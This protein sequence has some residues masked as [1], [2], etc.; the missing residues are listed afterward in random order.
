MNFSYNWLKDYFQKLPLPEK[1]ADV[2]TMHSFEVESV[3]KVGSDYILDIDVL[4]NRAA[5]CFS[6][7]GLAREIAA[8]L[9]LKIKKQ[10]VAKIR[11]QKIKTKDFISVKVEDKKSCLRYTA[12]VV[13]EVKV[14]PSP[15][16]IQER[17]ISCGL[18][19]INNI[20]DI[21]NYVMLE[22]GQPLH[23]FDFEKIREKKLIVRYANP[24]EKITTLDDKKFVLGE[25]IL[26]IA[27]PERVLAIAGI[28]GGKAAEIDE[29]TKTIILEAANFS[30]HIIRRGSKKLDL[31]TDASW[32]FENKIDPN[33]T[34]KAIERAAFLIQENAGGKVANDI[35]DF[36]PKKHVPREVKLS[37]DYVERLLGTKIPEREIKEILARLGFK[38]KKRKAK[39][40][41]VVVPTFRLD[42]HL[43]EDLIEEIGRIYGYEKIPA[44][45][46]L[47]SMVPPENNLP[48]YWENLIK[49]LFKEAGFSEVYNYSFIGEKEAKILTL[50]KEEIVEVENPVTDEQK[51]LRPS[52]IPNLLKNIRDDFRNSDEIKIFELENIFRNNPIAEK[53]ALAGAMASK[54]SLSGKNGFYAIKGSLDAIFNK[55]GIS[56]IYYDSYRQ[57]PEESRLAIWDEARSAEIKINGEEI[58]F[59]GV[60]SPDIAEAFGI[61]EEVAVFDLDFDKLSRLC[62]EEQQEYRPISMYPAAIRDLAVMVPVETKVEEI[63]NILEN[64]GGKLITDVDLFDIYEGDEL[65]EGRKSLAFHLTYQ[66]ENKTL[67]SREIDEIQNKIIKA[68]EETPE[69]EVR[70]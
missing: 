57:T 27:D 9:K 33:L 39:I 66:A 44:K 23:A 7:E 21:A 59:L 38:V 17:L 58:G 20:V 2:L 24:G 14:G 56:D 47:V 64:I 68:L 4:P 28:K 6:H 29:N 67:T 60:I 35:V 69:W 5:D 26:T 30:Y 19:P 22:T 16:W 36:Y 31:K 42:I 13:D 40:L 37:P 54:K 11:N 8:V 34:E 70:K 3:E 62:S 61:S 53:R 51:Y 15:K 41:S 1:L 52:L 49:N 43:P 25:D 63:L 10:P 46:P 65:P 32:R 18:R 55:I 12:K 45:F 48:L 50:K